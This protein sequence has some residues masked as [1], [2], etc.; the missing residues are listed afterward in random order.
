VVVDHFC[1]LALDRCAVDDVRR[2]VQN[3]TLGHRGRKGD[4][5]YG[6]RRLLL[7]GAERLGERGWARLAL[8]AGLAAGD[9]DGEVA[10]AVLGKDR[11]R[12][13]QLWQLAA[14]AAFALWGPVEDATNRSNPRPPNTLRRVEPLYSQ[15][16][17]RLV[18]TASVPRIRLHDLRHTHARNVA[19]P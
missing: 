16:F 7:V 9:A 11:P 14:A 15:S 18:A 2:R 3:E 6:I 1:V 17:D 10:A 4:P 5:L 8:S 12:L 13:P 19:S